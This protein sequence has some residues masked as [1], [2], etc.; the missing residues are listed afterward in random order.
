MQMDKASVLGDAVK[1]AKQLQERVQT[2]EEQAA[3]K[4]AESAVLVKRSVF[5]DEDA[6]RNGTSDSPYDQPLPEIEARVS[7]KDVLVR[8]HCDRHSGRVAT[9]L[10]ELEKYHLTVKSSSFLPFGNNIL[11][12]TIVAQVIKQLTNIIS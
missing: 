7:G 5:F 6:D 2:L 11:D 10:S 8:I 4:K 12:I 1:Y 3:K 9:I